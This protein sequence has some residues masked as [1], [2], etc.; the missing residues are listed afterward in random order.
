MST[1]SSYRDCNLGG[2]RADA[3]QLRP[4]QRLQNMYRAGIPGTPHAPR[5]WSGSASRD[6]GIDSLVIKELM[7]HDCLATT[8]IYVDVPVK[9]RTDAVGRLP[10]LCSTSAV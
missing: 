4:R 8:A 10:Q 9:Q 3:R 1:A 7:G 6:A 2:R 5:H